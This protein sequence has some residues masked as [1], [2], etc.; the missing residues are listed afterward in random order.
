MTGCKPEQGDSCRYLV[1]CGEVCDGAQAL[2]GPA[3][4]DPAV[5]STHLHL[6]GWR[7]LY[8]LLVN[9]QVG[10]MM[11]TFSMVVGDMSW[12]SL[13]VEAVVTVVQVSSISAVS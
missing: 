9:C 5:Y 1:T 4:V 12:D 11:R 7:G 6:E 8:Q 10:A 13:Q 3:T 2:G